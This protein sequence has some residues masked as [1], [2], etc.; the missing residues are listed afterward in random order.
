[1][2]L[3]KKERNWEMLG[4]TE[5]K[6]REMVR[7]HRVTSKKRTEDASAQEVCR[8]P[9]GVPIALPHVVSALACSRAKGR[10]EP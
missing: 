9:L 6:G 7:G 1:M 10:T 5:A 8:F 2:L 4:F 3:E